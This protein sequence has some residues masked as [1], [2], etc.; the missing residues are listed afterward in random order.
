MHEKTKRQIKEGVRK[1]LLNM[2]ISYMEPHLAY[3]IIHIVYIERL[4]GISFGLIE[5][6]LAPWNL[7][8]DISYHIYD[9][10][11]IILQ[12]IMFFFT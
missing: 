11:I 1:S 5:F 10:F 6:G 12:V 7:I 3:K 8:T 4:F 2:D 9:Q